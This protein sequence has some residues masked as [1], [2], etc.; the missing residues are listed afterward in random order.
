M[1]F[2]RSRLLSMRFLTLLVRNE[3]K[4]FADLP[5]QLKTPVDGKD[6]E[7]IPALNTTPPKNLRFVIGFNRLP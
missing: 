2:A 6:I 3:S 5:M 1:Y 4:G 7:K